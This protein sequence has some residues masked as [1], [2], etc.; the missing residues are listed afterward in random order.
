MRRLRAAYQILVVKQEGN[1]DYLADIG[2][3]GRVILKCVLRNK[4]KNVN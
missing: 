2:L 1:G 4:Y 3:E